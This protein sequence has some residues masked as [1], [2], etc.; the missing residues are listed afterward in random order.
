M[1]FG[2]LLTLSNTMYKSSGVKDDNASSDDGDRAPAGSDT[3][4]PLPTTG[5]AAFFFAAVSGFGARD[6]GFLSLLETS[7]GGRASGVP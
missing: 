4:L 6:F 3:L 5:L 7:A 1:H 2:I